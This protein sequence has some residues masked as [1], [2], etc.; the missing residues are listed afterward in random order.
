MI[1]RH[2]IGRT[3][4]WPI[5][6]TQA[7]TADVS[8]QW[9]FNAYMTTVSAALAVSFLLGWVIHP[10]LNADT[11]LAKFIDGVSILM[12]VG[13]FFF[14][15]AL[16]ALIIARLLSLRGLGGWG[17]TMLLGAALAWITAFLLGVTS[18]RIDD[19]VAFLG[20]GAIFGGLYWLSLKFIQPAVIGLQKERA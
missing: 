10:A 12:L 6:T 18:S 2:L 9:M 14:P 1:G 5:W 3:S 15:T 7:R 13:V 8:P 11:T 19:T 17:I 4:N 16:I 20:A